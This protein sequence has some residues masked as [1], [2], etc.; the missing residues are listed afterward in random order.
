MVLFLFAF[1]VVFFILFRGHSHGGFQHEGLVWNPRKCVALIDM[2][3]IPCGFH[4]FFFSVDFVQKN[5]P[6]EQPLVL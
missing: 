3:L 2:S 4:G 6:R 5:P 1:Y